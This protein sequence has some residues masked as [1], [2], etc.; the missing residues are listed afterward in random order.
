MTTSP[1]TV[2]SPNE[3][4]PAWHTLSIEDALPEQGVDAT[5]GLSQVEAERRLHHKSFG[6]SMPLHY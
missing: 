6:Q 2:S 1:S 5:T 3:Q 4:G